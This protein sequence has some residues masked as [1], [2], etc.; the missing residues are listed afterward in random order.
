MV[1]Q[2]FVSRR[3]GLNGVQLWLRQTSSEA[4]QGG[5]LTFSLYHWPGPGKPLATVQIPY[6]RVGREFPVNIGFPAQIDPPGQSYLITLQTTGSPLAVY[7]RAEDAYP[8]GSLTIRGETAAQDL[9]FRTSYLYDAGA[10]LE[11]LLAGFPYLWLALPL[12]LLLWAPGMLALE[13]SEALM[14]RGFLRSWDWSSRQ[15]LAIG[16]SMAL[17][18]LILLWTTALGLRWERWSVF[19]AAG[20]G[21]LAL[22]WLSF[23]RRRA[24]GRL[25]PPG[26]IDLALAGVFLLGLILRM[27]MVRDLAAP[28]WVDSVHHALISRMILEQGAY[29]SSYA[30]YVAAGT[31]SYHPGFHG[32]TAFFHW[33]TGIELSWAMLVFGQVLNALMAPALYLLTTQMTRDRRAGLIAAWIVSFLTPM[34]AYYVSWGRYT[35]LAGLLILPAGAAL[36]SRLLE[37]RVFPSGQTWRWSRLAIEP[38]QPALIPAFP[39]ALRL[40]IL[41]GLAGAGLLLVHYRVL[42]FLA[43][44]MTAAYLGEL[45]RSLDKLPLWKTLPR[46]LVWVGA[47]ALLG[48]LLSLPWWQGLIESLL[49]P[50]LSRTPAPPSPLTIDWGY[51]TPVFGRQALWL[52][53]AG[54]GLAVLQKRWFGPV[55]ALWVGLMF[56]SANQGV[57]RIP[58]AGMINKTSVEIALFMPTAALGGFVV[59]QVL[60]AAEGWLPAR[61]KRALNLLAAAA[62][63]TIAWFGAQRLL[64]IINP[65]TLLFRAADRPAIEWI[66]D[67][68]PPDET[69]LINPFL[70]GYGVFAGRDG[71]YWITPLS[72]RKSMPPNLL[73]GMGTRPDLERVNRISQ[74]TLDKAGSPPDLHQ[75]MV[76][77]QIRYLFIGRRGGSLSPHTLQASGLFETL[78]SQDGVWIFGVK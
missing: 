12:L 37:E 22:G 27:A 4:G 24:F 56:L 74:Q 29:P 75:M 55:L 31:A 39:S 20:L 57:L 18:P 6:D 70:W 49:A 77:E 28:A 47:A 46:S 1:G 7:G 73:Y 35:Q 44:L 58:G 51:L 64:P 60:A 32:L 36:L 61:G 30:P 8:D 68:I 33:L 43:L 76:A 53:A 16:L 69:I 2:T 13:L 10:F 21:V 11:D 48:V 54:L 62:A 34:P 63:L 41:T 23:R 45:I 3:P 59:S 65:S 42:G 5:Q 9:A 38:G 72:G 26:W 25:P 50:Q 15:A 66:A 71:G 67:H 19:T 40:L 17:V 78:Y 14:G 52:A